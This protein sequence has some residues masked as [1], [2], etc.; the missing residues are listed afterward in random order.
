MKA[1]V[2]D[3][4]LAVQDVADYTVPFPS[5]LA[6]VEL[7]GICNTDVELI[8]GYYDFQGILG[9]EFVATV[10]EG[11]SEWVGKRVVSE[12]N[13]GCGTCDLCQSGLGKLCGQRKAIGIHSLPGSFSEFV[14]LPLANLYP[15]PDTITDRQ[16]VFAE[17]LAAACELLE[18]SHIKPSDQVLLIGAGK[19]GLLCA[20]VVK[21]TGADLKVV[22]RRE[23][24]R[25]LLEKWQ[26]PAVTADSLEPRS[27]DSVIECTGNEAGLDQAIHLVKPRGTIHLKSTYAGKP[28]VD[29][30]P[31]VV[32]EI[33]L[34]G[35][36][37]GPFDTALRLLEK[38]LVDVESMIDAQFPLDDAVTAFEAAQAQ[39]ALKILIKP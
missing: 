4:A 36:R 25:Q 2:F 17:P 6:R 27:F 12:I 39:G 34:V 19:L 23:R 26:I 20:Q 18:V 31:I 9:H 37:C 30:S 3:G 13:V 16:A 24:Q 8:H 33:R 1:I 32:N 14:R 7:A 11:P 38:G 10:V 29:L 15:V 21:L 22:V 35:S 28:A 5:V